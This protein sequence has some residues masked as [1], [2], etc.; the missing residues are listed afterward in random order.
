MEQ[1][2]ERKGEGEELNDLPASVHH[3]RQD[4][5][6]VGY[7]THIHQLR[8]E[9]GERREGRKGGGGRCWNGV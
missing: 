5:K 1:E 9:G 8:E 6:V 4:N 7:H 2:V 3:E